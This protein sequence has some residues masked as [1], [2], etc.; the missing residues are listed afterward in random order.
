MDTWAVPVLMGWEDQFLRVINCA[1]FFLETVHEN[2]GLGLP[3]STGDKYWT[4]LIREA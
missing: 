2:H 1:I 3:L 4:P